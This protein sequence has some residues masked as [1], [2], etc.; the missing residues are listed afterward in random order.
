MKEQSRTIVGIDWS[1]DSHTCYDLQ[2]DKSFKITDSVEGYEKLLKNYPEAVF[3]IEEANNRIGDYLL[4]NN[5]EVYVLPP[6]RSK[7]ARKYHFS[8]G[9][10]SDGLDAKAIALTFKE[11]PSYCLKARYSKVGVKITKLVTAYNIV[12]KTHSQQ[13]NRLYSLLLRYFPEYL[14]IMDKQYRSDT[15]LRILS[16]CPTITELKK[17]SNEKLKKILNKE[18]YR[19]TSSLR[20]KLDRIRSEGISWEDT[21]C[22]GKLILLLVNTLLS[23]RKGLEVLK[24]EMEKTLKNSPYRIILSIPGVKAVIGSYIV[25][26]YLTHDFKSYQEIQKYA[27]TAPLLFQSGRKSIMLMRKKCDN[28]LKG[29]IHMAA[30]A[31]LKTCGWARNYYRRKRKEGKTYGHALRALGN[32]LLKIAFSML[33]KMKEYDETLFLNAKGIKTTQLND[34]SFSETFP[35]PE[36]SQDAQLSLAATK[37]VVD[38]LIVT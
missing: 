2:T 19:M 7:E 18:N 38:N 30:F 14:H 20:N 10:K 11:H 29:M 9:T 31:S 12:S 35:Y 13:C 6:C 37:D 33:S 24:K 32:I 5:R 23:L 1:A 22:E 3:V 17:V 28:D 15:S 34:T 25:K 8:S 16:V 21:S 27:G 4:I 36:Y 26:A